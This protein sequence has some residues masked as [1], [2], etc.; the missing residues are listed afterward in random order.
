[1]AEADVPSARELLNS[2]LT[3]FHLAPVL[4][5]HDFKH[6]LLPR[7]GVVDTF[8]VVDKDGRVTDMCRYVCW[9]SVVETERETLE[10]GK[11]QRQ[12]YA[13]TYTH[14]N[15]HTHTHTYSFYHLPSTVINNAKH[16]TLRAVYS[17]YNVAT[18]MTL[19]VRTSRQKKTNYKHTQ[20]H[21]LSPT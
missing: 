12:K 14:T 17:F 15:I 3:K 4:D 11:A 9:C 1:M 13:L 7:E 21:T 19:K 18:T 6:W 5:D 2:Y 16:S 10:R 20:T 8:V